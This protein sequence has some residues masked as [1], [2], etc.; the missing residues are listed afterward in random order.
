[1]G[2]KIKDLV[3]PIEIQVDKLSGKSVAVDGF[4][5]ILQFL[6]TIRLADGSLLTDRKG[7]IT[8]HL[9]GLFFRLA[10]L[11]SNGVSP[12]FVLDG[13]APKLKRQTLIERGNMRREAM[14]MA[15]TAVTQEEK[16]K[17]LKRAAS[18]N[19]DIIDSTKRLLDLMGI[20]VVQAP[21][22]GESE[23]AFLNKEGLVYA[24]ASQ[25]YDSLLFGCRRLVRNLN[26]TG[27]RK[28]QGKGFFVKVNPELI[29]L[30]DLLS[31]NGINHDQLIALALLVGTDYNGGVKGIGPKKA[32]AIV[33]KDPVE[34]ILSSYDFDT[35]NNIREVF[36]Y[37]KH[38]DVVPIEK[39]PV[40]EPDISALR[41]F[42][43]DEHDFSSS[44]F[45]SV[46]EK[47]KRS[48]NSLTK[49]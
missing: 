16:R 3:H 11:L 47:L 20:P 39:V 40:K 38:P 23:A 28:A 29:L 19:D 26:I 14:E 36:D 10:F 43:V 15:E 21:A 4:N 18:V 2:V 30:D 42:L 27:R 37:F 9:D 33:K 44:R 35:E 24:V 13:K 31:E 34:K 46:V 41:K 6:T 22:E 12:V 7:R 45:E 48:D 8:S 1:M 49:F 32:L 25:D 17:Y 5:W